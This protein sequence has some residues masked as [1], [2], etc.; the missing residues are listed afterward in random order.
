ML[1]KKSGVEQK[2]QSFTQKTPNNSSYWQNAIGIKS[3]NIPFKGNQEMPSSEYLEQK[4]KYLE[5]MMLNSDNLGDAPATF[6]TEVKLLAPFGKTAVDKKI[7]M[8]DMKVV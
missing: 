4:I 7:F 1:K 6:E 2:R 3:F 8:K 5:K